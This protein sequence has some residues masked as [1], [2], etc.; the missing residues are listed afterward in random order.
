MMSQLVFKKVPISGEIIKSIIDKF[1]GPSA[2]LKDIRVACIYSLGFAGFF[3]Y[4]ELSNIAPLHLEFFP[5]H[6]RVF[7]T[8]AKNDIYC[9]SNYVYIKRLASQYCLVL[10]LERYI[11]MCNIEL[12]SSVALFRPIRLYVHQF[13]QAI[14]S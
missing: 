5:D 3:R 13:F 7:A 9:E 11:S 10:L 12:S 4:N 1:A 14:W 2:N 6:L 8:R